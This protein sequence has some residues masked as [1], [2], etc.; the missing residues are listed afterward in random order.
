LTNYVGEVVESSTRRFI[1]RSKNIGESPCFGCF[2]KTDSNPVVYGVVYEII[3]ESKE[4]GRRPETYGMS[5]KELKQAQPQIFELLKT[6][7]HVLTIAYLEKEKVV[8]S[9]PPIPPTIHSFVYE[10]TREEVKELTS[11]DFFL[12]IIISSPNIPVDELIISA[13]RYSQEARGNDTDY[14]IRVGK[15]LARL[16]KDDY[17]R[18]S[19]VLRRVI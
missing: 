9:L 10:C 17:E 6:E 2:V 8:F 13:I 7:F 4:P 5:L 14:V 3:T 18:L 1:A 16:F 12:R 11:E 15:S 19:S